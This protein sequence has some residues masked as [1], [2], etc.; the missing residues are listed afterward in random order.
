MARP[1]RPR[2]LTLNPSAVED[3]LAVARMSKKQLCDHVGLTPSHLADALHRR[4]GVAREM[5]E[6]MATVLRCRPGTLAPELHDSFTAIRGNDLDG[7]AVSAAAA[8]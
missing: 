6:S 1:G 5:V 4:K 7:R 8:S 3:M 2:A